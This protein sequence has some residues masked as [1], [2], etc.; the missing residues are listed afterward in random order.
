MKRK[1]PFILLL[2]FLLSV[3]IALFA[4]EDK[5]VKLGNKVS[6]SS[7]NDSWIR[8][9]VPFNILNHPGLEQFR[10]RRPS[11][12][13]ELFNPEYIDDLKVKIFLCFTN[14]FKKK[15][16]RSSQFP[17][18]NFYQ[19]YSAELTYETIKLDRNT[20][21]ANFL[22]P[23]AIAERDGFSGGYIKPTG[24]AIE[25]SIGGRSMDIS[26]AI[27]F[28]KFNNDEATLLKFKQ[29]AQEKSSA[30]TD[31]LVPAHYIFP[32]YHLKDAKLKAYSPNN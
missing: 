22:F 19:Y 2:T 28:D 7:E 8:V 10:T 24:Y 14:E 23:A 31:T 32:A 5:Y 4:E 21:Y 9:S 16:L 17:D 27:V 13:E 26:N 29:Q 6:I 20:K 11:T 25:I 18:S 30:N 1:T 12:V 15:T 3:K